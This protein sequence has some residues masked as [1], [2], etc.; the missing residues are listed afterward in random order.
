MDTRSARNKNQPV[1]LERA[2]IL[3]V[4]DEPSLRRLLKKALDIAGYEITEAADGAEG[5]EKLQEERFDLLLTDN[6]MPKISGEQ[7]SQMARQQW[8][9]LRI[10]L[11]T[12][13]PPERC[14][15]QAWD[16]TLLK[17][18]SI[19]ELLSVVEKHLQYAHPQLK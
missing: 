4:D 14:T 1:N 13:T 15:N 7:L 9:A 17:P 10:V 16:E 12:G 11:I 5:W 18:F 3:L 8:G 6:R 19:K 2:K